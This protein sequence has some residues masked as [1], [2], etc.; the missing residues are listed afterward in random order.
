MP[1][2]AALGFKVITSVDADH[3]NMSTVAPFVETADFFT[4]DSPPLLQTQ[5]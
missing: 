4:L 2:V 5:P 3:I 1:A